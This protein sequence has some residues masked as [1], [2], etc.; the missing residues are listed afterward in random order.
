M[1]KDGDF[2]MRSVQHWDVG[3]FH[4]SREVKLARRSSRL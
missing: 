3:G 4:N 1:A 2:I